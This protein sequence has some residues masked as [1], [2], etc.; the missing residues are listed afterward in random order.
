M[1]PAGGYDLVCCASFRTRSK[2]LGIK[3]KLT[4]GM[5]AARADLHM[6]LLAQTDLMLATPPALR[7]RMLRLVRPI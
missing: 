3:R 4:A 7:N 2:V 5:S 6:G 1:Q